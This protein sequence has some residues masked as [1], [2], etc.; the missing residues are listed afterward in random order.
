MLIA[1]PSILAC[2]SLALGLLAWVL[3]TDRL[4]PLSA[5]GGLNE[6]T[7]FRVISLLIVTS[8]FESVSELMMAGS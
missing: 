8:F 7:V 5:A 2:K 4:R 1:L 6:V 3:V